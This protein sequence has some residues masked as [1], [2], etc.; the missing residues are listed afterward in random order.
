LLEFDCKAEV[1]IDTWE[2][3]SRYHEFELHEN[4][5]T[6]AWRSYQVGKGKRF[7]KADL[8]AKYKHGATQP[9]TGAIF[10]ADAGKSNQDFQPKLEK[11]SRRKRQ[12]KVDKVEQTV[13]RNKAKMDVSKA[14]QL[15]LQH[16]VAERVPFACQICDRRFATEYQIEGHTCQLPSPGD[17]TAES[18]ATETTTP[19]V[20]PITVPV[21]PKTDHRK[22]AK[23]AP[24]GS[25]SGAILLC[26][27]I[28]Q[29]SQGDFGG[30]VSE[31]SR[32]VQQPKGR[33]RN[34]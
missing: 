29:C 22:P 18:I 25:W 3:I 1:E 16:A 12:L 23:M 15:K 21:S 24:H 32:K 5:D 30:T 6:T 11:S 27:G 8:D 10:V 2:G 9:S 26:G 19:V 13:A 31:R 4:G 34:G 17:T 28:G 20:S 14:A 7:A 33:A